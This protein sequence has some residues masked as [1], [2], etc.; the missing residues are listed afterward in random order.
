MT[1]NAEQ[2]MSIPKNTFEIKTT[3]SIF[4]FDK[5]SSEQQ[6]QMVKM[7]NLIAELNTSTRVQ[8]KLTDYLKKGNLNLQTFVNKNKKSR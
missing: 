2:M 8:N 4:N 7:I 6:H 1:F 3:S 5:L